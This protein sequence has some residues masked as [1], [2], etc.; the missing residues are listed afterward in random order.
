[1]N[2]DNI[3]VDT[4]LSLARDFRAQDLS[5]FKEQ[6]DLLKKRDIAS[7]RE[8]AFPGR[9]QAPIWLHKRVYQMESFF[10]RYTFQN[11]KYTKE[12]LEQKANED[13]VA[14]QTKLAAPRADYLCSTKVVIKLARKLVRE[15]LGP[16][17][18]DEHMRLCRFGKRAA[19]GVTAKEAFLDRKVEI[20]SCSEGHGLWFLHDYVTTDKI[21]NDACIYSISQ[22]QKEGTI[23]TY[24]LERATCLSLVNVPKKYNTFRSI[25]PNTVIGGF[26]SLGLGVYIE[27][28]LR[29][30]NRDI[31]KLQDVHKKLAQQASKTR[32]LV[33]LDVSKAS[34]NFQAS[35]VNMLCPRAWYNA[36]KFG[37]IT[38]A[39]LSNDEECYLQSFMAM[40]IGFTFP[41]QTLL[42]E[43][44]IRAIAS[45]VGIDSKETI[46]VYGDDCIY[47][48]KIHK[49][50]IA[51]F[52]DLG[53]TPNMDKTFDYHFFRESCGGDYYHG[54]DVRPYSPN[55]TSQ[56][57]Y[58]VK[59]E[60]F[61]YKILNGLLRRW[62]FAEIPQ[63]VH[64]LLRII[65][66][67][68]GRVY[69]VPPSFPDTSGV[70]VDC[71][72]D[73]WYIP[74]S[75]VYWSSTKA[76]YVFPYLTKEAG[77]RKVRS[78]YPYYWNSMRISSLGKDEVCT[79]WSP[80]DNAPVEQLTWV[81]TKPAKYCTSRI[82]K[83]RLVTTY[84][85]TPSKVGFRYKTK[86]GETLL[87]EWCYASVA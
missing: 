58:G 22:A 71:I 54:V 87:G 11:D 25:M 29:K 73:A 79:D 3:M 18:P 9:M 4:W 49:Y 42:F 53:F 27:D 24:P 28:R 8:S 82:T 45:L 44:V 19:V 17:D 5:L 23:K 55:A 40:G 86:R 81:K 32:H 72:Q 77:D 80:W 60:A 66:S 48:R 56:D 83:Q 67:S 31:R 37:R 43:S 34:E 84:A 2:T 68:A 85:V 50:V 76:N 78:V 47:P 16:Y 1:M 61:C 6:G 35:L 33:T 70:K 13:F 38:K 39:R 36:L 63:A 7:F 62:D 20:L 69:Q 41:L 75:R 51:V 59:L 74:W 12:S 15:A 57:L 10:K 21:L 26:Y 65:S 46:S 52:N 64:H 14:F 30:I